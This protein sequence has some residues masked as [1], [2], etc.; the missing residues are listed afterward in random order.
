MTPPPGIEVK[1]KTIFYP[2]K[3]PISSISWIFKGL[4]MLFLLLFF[5]KKR[6]AAFEE[7]ADES[8]FQNR[9]F[10]FQDFFHSWQWEMEAPWKS[11]Q[12]KSEQVG[13]CFGGSGNSN[14]KFPQVLEKQSSFVEKSTR[15]RQVQ[16]SGYG[17]WNSRQRILMPNAWLW[18]VFLIA[19]QEVRCSLHGIEMLENPFVAFFL[20]C[21]VEATGLNGSIGAGEIHG[22]KEFRNKLLYTYMYIYIYI[23]LY[24]YIEN[25]RDTSYKDLDLHKILIDFHILGCFTAHTRLT[26]CSFAFALRI[27]VGKA[28]GKITETGMPSGVGKSLCPENW[29]VKNQVQ[30]CQRP[31][32]FNISPWKQAIPKGFKRKGIFQRIF[33]P[34]FLR[35][36]VS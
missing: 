1:S 9:F 10:P 2:P 14:E 11:W 25:P 29:F 3:S 15:H 17:E 34:S 32:K 36:D 26:D 7:E 19:L 13:S 24:T 4:V 28:V 22:S 20:F 21:F 16:E 18:V 12:A 23:Y 27:G 31:W 8:S 30:T 33:Q 6:G 5:G 35:G